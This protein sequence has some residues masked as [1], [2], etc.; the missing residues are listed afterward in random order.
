L[1]LA[2]SVVALASRI[3]T[4][5]VLLLAFRAVALALRFVVLALRVVVVAV[6]LVIVTL[7][8]RAV[9]LTLRFVVLALR[10]VVVALALVI[11]TLT[12]RVVVSALA[13]TP[14]ALSTSLTRSGADL[15]DGSLCEAQHDE[16]DVVGRECDGESDG[17]HGVLAGE[18]DRLAA[19]PVCHRREHQRA[20]HHAEVEHRL[21]RL[22]EVV[23][24]A[25]QVPLHDTAAHSSTDNNKL[26]CR[27][28]TARCVVSAEI[29]PIA[30]Q[31][32]RNY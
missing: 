13:L 3:V 27:R 25:H 19:E 6:A 1:A 14:V 15:A 32:C 10:V 16:A 17:E 8:L 12:A 20:D 22:D 29:L 5:R 7:T 21:R 30:T 2:L 18:V 9:A 26:S 11:V 4:V 23:L 31:Q 28:R 24:V